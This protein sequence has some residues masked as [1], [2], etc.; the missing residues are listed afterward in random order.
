LTTD[1]AGSERNVVWQLGGCWLCG[2]GVSLIFSK[3]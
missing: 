1:D 3:H 2:R